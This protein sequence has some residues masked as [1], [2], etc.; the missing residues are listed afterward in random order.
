MQQRATE[1]TERTETTEEHRG[2][3]EAIS[4]LVGEKNASELIE[5]AIVESLPTGPGRRNKQVFELA[6]ALKAIPSIVD[7]HPGRIEAVR[8][9]MA[10]SCEARDSD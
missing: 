9:P 4:G 5:A 3:T 7:A 1:T 8:S 2:T 10:H 6:R